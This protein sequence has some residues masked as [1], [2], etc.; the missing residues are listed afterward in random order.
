M[1]CNIHEVV[2]EK[3]LLNGNNAFF[4]TFKAKN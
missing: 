1:S 2:H 3:S 4:E